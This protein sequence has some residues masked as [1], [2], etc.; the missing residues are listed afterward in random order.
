V[1]LPQHV[2]ERRELSM[3]DFVGPFGLGGAQRRKDRTHHPVAAL[4]QVDQPALAPGSRATFEIA[5]RFKLARG[6]VGGLTRHADLTRIE[7][8]MMRYG[9]VLA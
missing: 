4:G 2:H 5:E 8:I 1:K 9:L 6:I 7:K 3:A